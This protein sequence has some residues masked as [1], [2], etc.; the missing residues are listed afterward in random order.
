MLAD[1]CCGF[2]FSLSDPF[3]HFPVKPESGKVF[4]LGNSVFKTAFDYAAIGEQT[5]LGYTPPF[6]AHVGHYTSLWYLYVSAGFTDVKPVL[7]VWGFRPT[8]ATLPAFRK[9]EP[10]DVDLFRQ[11]WD[12]NYLAKT[13]SAQLSLAERFKIRLESASLFFGQRDRIRT[14][15]TRG[16]NVLVRILAGRDTASAQGIPI[17][18]VVDGRVTVADLVQRFGSGGALAFTEQKVV[19]A[20]KSFITGER[21]DFAGSFI[22]DIV[23]RLQAK[24]IRQ[25]VVIFKPVAYTEG[26]VPPA[27]REFVDV[28]L[29]YLQG[30][31]IPYLDFVDDDRI[32]KQLYAEGDHYNAEGRELLTRLMSEKLREV[33]GTSGPG[34]AGAQ[35]DTAR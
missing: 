34:T 35:P 5:G 28:T 32:Q 26:P 21:A 22:P 3:S 16:I 27:D 7:V 14:A 31:N 30:R 19:D 11:Y 23:D 20:G 17:D 33:M 6:D 8:Y 29:R 10:C 25:L 24:G 1:M 12:E 4:F 18:A 13:R 9:R 2:A 15:V